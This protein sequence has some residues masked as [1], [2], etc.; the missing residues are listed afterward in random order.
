MQ[1]L[2]WLYLVHTKKETIVVLRDRQIDGQDTLPSNI[3]SFK[4]EGN[5]TSAETK[6]K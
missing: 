2:L 1:R 6:R 5:P 3:N 4:H